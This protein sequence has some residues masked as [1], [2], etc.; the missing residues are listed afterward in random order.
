MPI[1]P[2]QEFGEANTTPASPD[3]PNGAYKNETVPNVSQD[4]TPMT[5]KILNDKLGADEALYAD[6]GIT[7]TNVADTAQS[8][9]KLDA[10]RLLAGKTALRP[11]LIAQGLTGEYGY[12]STGFT[13]NDLNDVGV[14]DSGQTWRY[15]GSDPLPLVVAAG[16][17]PSAPDW[18]A[19]RFDQYAR[20]MTLAEAITEDMPTGTKYIIN[21]GRYDVVDSTDTGGYYIA[22]LASGRKLRLIHGE[23][24]HLEWFGEI[25]NLSQIMD[26]VDDNAS[27]V[28]WQNIT[29][30]TLNS[31]T[32]Q[33]CRS[34][35]FNGA[36]IDGSG[37]VDA[38]ITEVLLIQGDD[39]T[40][41]LPSLSS[42][43]GLADRNISFS[44]AHG[45][46][47][48]DWFVIYDPR[49]NSYSPARTDYRAGE[50]LQ[51]EEVI[52]TTEVKIYGSVLSDDD[53]DSTE[54]ELYKIN[55]TRFKFTGVIT[56]VTPELGSNIRAISAKN[57]LDTDFSNFEARANE[58]VIAMVLT[59]CINSSGTG[60][61]CVQSGEVGVG[62]GLATVSCQNINFEGVFKGNRHGFTTAETTGVSVV[63]R[64]GIIQGF[65]E[66]ARTDLAACD[67]HGNTE[68][69]KFLGFING[70][71]Q[72]RGNH[73]SAK[74]TIR[75]DNSGRC[76]RFEELTGYDHDISGCKLIGSNN[77][78]AWGIV[79]VGY[80]G[81]TAEPDFTI[82]KGGLMNLKNLS[83][84]APNASLIVSILKKASLATDVKI[85]LRGLSITNAQPLPTVTFVTQA[86]AKFEYVDLSDFE[87]ITN[88]LTVTHSGLSRLKARIK[89][90]E[91]V[92]TDGDNRAQNTVN[93]G[94]SFGTDYTPQVIVSNRT[95]GNVNTSSGQSYI[96]P[97]GQ[98]TGSTNS[99]MIIGY[100]SA[101]DENMIS[102]QTRNINWE[103]S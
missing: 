41:P 10:L 46:S 25:T 23:T 72:L 69:F 22:I 78:S 67:T 71:L 73:L 19:V 82:T 14:T 98:M 9:Q 44:T 36:T 91:G 47:V 35:S 30:P 80:S 26:Y 97:Y 76:V 99:Q 60:L 27:H 101:T 59:R 77:N 37:I 28:V 62:Y 5:A 13:I 7:P 90:F 83:I 93:I 79:S 55:P 74:A 6:V 64:N 88:N 95:S 94:L 89:G 54:V 43:I 102:G 38:S 15:V 16:T 53:Y 34:H 8:S 57:T 1:K 40:I 18:G 45:L 61:V 20:T 3:Y 32:L 4:G 63:N 17:V 56:A 68:H 50:Y 11:V 33:N 21:N 51:V 58:S 31:V 92:T 52:S 66:S 29:Y 24:I 48:G 12:F 103:V 81:T 2:S 70:G 39:S 86:A 65:F 84:D 100:G 96:I 75:A 87:D 42:N 49:D 85:D